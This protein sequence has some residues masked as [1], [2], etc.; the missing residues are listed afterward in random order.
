MGTASLKKYLTLSALCALLAGTLHA[1]PYFA[2]PVS[3]R[4]LYAAAR[5]VASW[6]GLDGF[7]Q[8]SWMDALAA[9][10]WRTGGTGALACG[11]GLAVL[12]WW[13]L[14]GFV[15]LGVVGAGLRWV[16][17]RRVRGGI[18]AV[19]VAVLVASAAPALWRESFLR[20]EPVRDIRLQMATELAE[21]IG[22][23]NDGEVFANPT[24]L[25]QF[26]LFAPGAVGK[27]LPPQSAAL[28]VS[29][30][31]WR[32][33]L[34]GSRWKAVALSGP[35]GEFRPLLDHL[36]I[37]PD[38]RL[39]L[40]SNH[41]YLFLRES[42]TPV[43]SIDP[44]ALRLGSDGE[45]AIYLAQIAER[46]D[47]IRRPADAVKCLDRALELA[48]EN[49]T[50]LSHAAT[51][52]AGRKRWQDALAYSA[53]ALAQAPG[54]VHAKL[55][56]SLALLETG[57]AREAQDLCGEVL[58]EA[59]NDPYSLFLYARICRALNDYAQESSTLERLVALTEQSG[60]PTINY[61]IY[62]GQAYAR[63][64][65]PEPAL[66]NYRIVLDSG[67]LPPDQADEIRDAIS[68]IEENAPKE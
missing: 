50:V 23:V 53:R 49:V 51:F 66:K 6:Q 30:P 9:R 54:S 24:T 32:Q 57:E 43:K 67:L 60:L 64:G 15:A 33:A 52:A 4:A 12:A 7:G 13:T 19:A 65:Q 8:A 58:A 35:I 47:A 46:Y 20:G 31:A 3:Q 2:A 26:L 17:S 14:A 10:L 28:S 63:Q 48:P 61:R 59:P 21:A 27:I 16:K 44:M 42:G 40:V 37:S 56:R 38:W 11:E 55:V 18:I 29:P 68:A 62:L 5:G 1:W 39:S 36:L 22:G 34:R 41:G 45:T 25:S